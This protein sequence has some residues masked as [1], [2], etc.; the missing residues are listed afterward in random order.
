M[1]KDADSFRA[2]FAPLLFSLRLRFSAAKALFHA[3]AHSLDLEE[4]TDACS[5]DTFGAAESIDQPQSQSGLVDRRQVQTKII[6]DFFRGYLVRL[7]PAGGRCSERKA[8]KGKHRGSAG[9]CQ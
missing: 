3:R 8:G 2:A 1:D 4:L 7:C 9:S 6:D 5:Q